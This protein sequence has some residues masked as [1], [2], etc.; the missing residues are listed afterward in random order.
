MAED[1]FCLSV[2]QRIKF[3]WQ[4]HARPKPLAKTFVSTVEIRQLTRAVA[5]SE[6]LSG[7]SEYSWNQRSQ[8][9]CRAKFSQIESALDRGAR[10]GKAVGKAQSAAFKIYSGKNPTS[11][12]GES[13]WGL[14]DH[15]TQR[16]VAM[17]MC[18]CF[19][20]HISLSPALCFHVSELCR[21]IFWDNVSCHLSR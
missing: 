18:P 9:N 14:G 11:T 16:N 17:F 1:M 6:I 20:G 19:Q 4:T 21:N 2:K 7:G 15:S 5:V 3:C 12:L 10:K 13:A 8:E